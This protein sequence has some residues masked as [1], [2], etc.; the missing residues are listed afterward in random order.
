MIRARKNSTD[1]A[2]LAGLRPEGVPLFI[3]RLSRDIL[4]LTDLIGGCQ[5]ETIFPNL[6][7]LVKDLRS[8]LAR[9]M[10]CLNRTSSKPL[11]SWFDNL[12]TTRSEA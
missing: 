8:F 3:A 11:H 6:L 9:I 5:A 10:Q 12:L 1:Q 4:S 2:A 7:V